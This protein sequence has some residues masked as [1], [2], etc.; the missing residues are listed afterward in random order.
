MARV[1]E[2]HSDPSG[3]VIE[4]LDPPSLPNS[5]EELTPR[6]KATAGAGVGL[7]FGLAGLR[8]FAKRDRPGYSTLAKHRLI[9]GR[10][11]GQFTRTCSR[12]GLVLP[13]IATKLIL[14]R[15]F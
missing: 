1:L 9:V 6:T 2:G 4:Q 3:P 12:L 10:A 11:A 13:P 15:V 7:L 5:Y 8:F 14:S